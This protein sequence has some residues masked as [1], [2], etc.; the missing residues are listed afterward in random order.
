MNAYTGAYFNL[1]TAEQCCKGC[2][3]TAWCGGFQL[4]RTN[5]DLD[6]YC[7]MVDLSAGFQIDYTPAPRVIS[8]VMPAAP[9][10]PSPPAELLG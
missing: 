6:H 7:W 9:P 1:T 2:A 4:T 10:P 3:S 8:Y 5:N